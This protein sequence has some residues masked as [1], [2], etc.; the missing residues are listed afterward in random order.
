MIAGLQDDFEDPEQMA[1]RAA[2]PM[3]CDGGAF[4][5]VERCDPTRID[6]ALGCD[7]LEQSGQQCVRSRLMPGVQDEYGLMA[8]QM[9]E[10]VRC[11]PGYISHE[12]FVAEDGERV[13]LVEF[14]SQ[15]ALNE[16]KVHPRHLEAKRLGF[17]RFFS[18]FQ[19]QICDVA[20]AAS[21]ESKIKKQ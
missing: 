12:G 17:T 7:G 14:E 15:E 18:S 5:G 8:K 1:D 9:I 10:L 19:Y 2:G 6:A 3:F 16:W 13:T 11:M 20:H 4:D 21:W